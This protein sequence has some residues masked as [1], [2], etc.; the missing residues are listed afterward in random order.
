[1]DEVITAKFVGSGK[2]FETK[3][4]SKSCKGCTKIQEIKTI[5]LQ[6]SNKWNSIHRCVLY[7]KG[8]S[9]TMETAGAE[10][11]FKQ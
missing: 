2:V 3:I 1:M 11:M 7:Y 10:K 4:L 5:Y 6:S 9:P 8:S